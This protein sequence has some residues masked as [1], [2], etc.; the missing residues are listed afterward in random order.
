[1]FGYGQ[2]D[3]DNIVFQATAV[4]V[5]G[6]VIFTDKIASDSYS[7]FVREAIFLDTA[8]MLVIGRSIGLFML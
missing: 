6:R 1:M 3:I 2:E 5:S 7:K 4:C 8:K